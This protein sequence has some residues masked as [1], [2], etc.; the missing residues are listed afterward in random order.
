MHEVLKR[1][2][3]IHTYD[4]LQIEYINGLFFPRRLTTHLY[5]V[6]D[7]FAP[8]EQDRGDHDHILTESRA[9]RIEIKYLEPKDNH[10]T[11]TVRH[12]MIRGKGA[13]CDIKHEQETQHRHNLEMKLDVHMTRLLHLKN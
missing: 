1:K 11:G 12:D 13:K 6:Q 2:T 5:S 10:H 4:E 9:E 7:V 3:D 8:N